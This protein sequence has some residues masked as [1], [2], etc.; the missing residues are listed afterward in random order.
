MLDLVLT[1][2]TIGLK[3]LYEKNISYYNLISDFRKKLPRPQNEARKITDEEIDKSPFL[4]ESLKY[5]N[6]LDVSTHKTSIS[7]QELDMFINSI[8]HFDYSWMFFKSYYKAYSRNVLRFK[9]ESKN[10][11]FELVLLQS[12]LK[13][14]PIHPL[15]PFPVLVHQLKFS[16][17]PFSTIYVW[18]LKRKRKQYDSSKSKINFG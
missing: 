17:K 16:K 7:E 11:N 9:P 15:K 2:L 5:I 12:V 13:D 1:I 14:N 4:P 8:Q 18:N 10:G 3:P 6:A